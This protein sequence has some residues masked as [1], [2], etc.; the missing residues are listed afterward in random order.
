MT[1]KARLGKHARPL[2]QEVLL[3][4]L[5]VHRLSACIIQEQEDVQS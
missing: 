5:L 1:D 4:A 2:I 3:F